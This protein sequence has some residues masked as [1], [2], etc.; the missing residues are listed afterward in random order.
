MS[1]KMFT[2]RGT[3]YGFSLIFELIRFEFY[4]THYAY[5]LLSLKFDNYRKERLKSGE[6]KVKRD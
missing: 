1:R 6:I 4:E 2:N 3:H 5:E